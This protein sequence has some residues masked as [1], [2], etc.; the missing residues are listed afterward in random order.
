MWNSWFSDSYGT[1]FS[2]DQSIPAGY[3]PQI[4]EGAFEPDLSNPP[5][6][7]MN[8][9]YRD[10]SASGWWNGERVEKE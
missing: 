1:N 6:G 3:Q 8:I 5:S 2:C 10:S 4:R 9:H 7:G